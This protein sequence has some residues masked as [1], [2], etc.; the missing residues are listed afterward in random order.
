MV[1]L[2]GLL[3]LYLNFGSCKKTFPAYVMLCITL[4]LTVLAS[5]YT[6]Q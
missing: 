2:L 1:L 4:L 6:L 5:L 3:M